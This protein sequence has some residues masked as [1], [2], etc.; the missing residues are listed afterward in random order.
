MF[1]FLCVCGLFVYYSYV[2]CSV[3]ELNL[4]C[5][6]KDCEKS[7]SLGKQTFCKTV[8]YLFFI[9]IILSFSNEIAFL[10]CTYLFLTSAN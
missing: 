1:F 8:F 3:I 5:L 10:I 7:L 6:L 4:C 9:A 2:V